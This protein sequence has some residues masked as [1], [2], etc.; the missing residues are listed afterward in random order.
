MM[1]SNKNR[2]SSI[3]LDCENFLLRNFSFCLE[4]D[5]DIMNNLRKIVQCDGDEL[6]RSLLSPHNNKEMWKCELPYRTY[7]NELSTGL[8]TILLPCELIDLAFSYANS[9]FLDALEI[10]CAIDDPEKKPNCIPGRSLAADVCHHELYF[11]LYL[12]C[13]SDKNCV[14]HFQNSSSGALVVLDR[15]NYSQL[16]QLV[17]NQ[18]LADWLQCKYFAISPEEF[19]LT[20]IPEL[21]DH[22]IS[23][24][25]TAIHQIV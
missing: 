13:R 21:I 17:R 7:L 18:T 19:R 4:A 6:F 2:V 15:I 1:R 20:F 11:A 22:L 9:I 8:M 5:I 14:I 3:V 24:I 23:H 12:D 10:A 25:D 16:L